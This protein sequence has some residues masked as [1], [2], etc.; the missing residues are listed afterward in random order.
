MSKFRRALSRVES[1]LLWLSKV[2]WLSGSGIAYVVTLA[3]CAD[4]ASRWITGSSI[5]GMYEA[6]SLAVVF[7]YVYGLPQSIV[8]G[9]QLRLDI[10]TKH[11]TGR[12]K[13]GLDVMANVLLVAFFAIVT[14]YSWHEAVVSV[15]E[16]AYFGSSIRVDRVYPWSLLG[17]ILSVGLL[18]TIRSLVM[19]LRSL[20]SPKKEAMID[21]DKVIAIQ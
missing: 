15:R 10:L 14:Y 4:V 6:I 18:V 20:F 11:F 5:L 3:I 8:S 1:G 2:S 21:I 9:R 17:L 16:H 13:S 12:S 7:L 19:S